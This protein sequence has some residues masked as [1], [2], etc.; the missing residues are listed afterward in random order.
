[1]NDFAGKRFNLFGASRVG[2][3]LAYHLNRLGFKPEFVWNRSPERLVQAMKTVPFQNFSTDLTAAC[4]SKPDWVII[5]VTD[6]AI[7]EIATQIS[8]CLPD[9]KA[10]KVFHTS[11]F[12]SSMA[13]SSLKRKG[14]ATGSLHP[15]VS[16]PDI[17]TGIRLLG[18][19]V[20][21]CEGVIKKSLAEIVR[22]IGGQPYLLNRKQKETIHL[23]AVFLN[24][25]VVA[26]ISAIKILN[27]ESDLEPSKA[28]AILRPITEQAV[29][30]G[31]EKNVADAL[32][33]PLMRGDYQTIE[34]HLALLNNYPELKKL[35]QDFIDLALQVVAHSKR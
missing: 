27:S 25:Y 18:Q 24:N 3:S 6:D 19:C 12:L 21:T 11:G 10:V 35:Y 29:L 20:Y 31:W 16:V 34:K 13:L 2:V 26:L 28:Q 5:A 1:M 15:V 23:S 14:A 7:E 17:A 8:Q 9:F 4:R 22:S 30:N 32:T 33:G